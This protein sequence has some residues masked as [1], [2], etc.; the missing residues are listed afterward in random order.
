MTRLM[1]PYSL[2]EDGERSYI[3]VGNNYYAGGNISC[4]LHLL[5]LLHFIVGN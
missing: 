4:L 5:H 1:Q 3:F 2:I